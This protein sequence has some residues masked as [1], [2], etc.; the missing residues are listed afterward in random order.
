MAR[1]YTAHYGLYPWELEDNFG[2]TELSQDNAKIDA[3]LDALDGGRQ[4]DTHAGVRSKRGV[5]HWRR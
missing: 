2:C 1:D 5:Y 3:A 4:L